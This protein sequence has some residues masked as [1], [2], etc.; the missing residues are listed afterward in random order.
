MLEYTE[1]I[2]F[3]KITS[4]EQATG[5]IAC[6]SYLAGCMK[7]SFSKK[8]DSCA[9]GKL[10]RLYYDISGIQVESICRYRYY[11]LV[12]DDATRYI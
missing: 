2:S 12:T 4:A 10:V 7:E 1:R 9:K 6:E 3:C 8:I 5:E 11:L